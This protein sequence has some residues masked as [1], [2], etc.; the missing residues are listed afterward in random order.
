MYLELTKKRII[1]YVKRT[2]M[3]KSSIFS[4]Q[5][6]LQ[7]TLLNVTIQCS[8]SGEM[9]P[10]L[11][12]LKNGIN[13]SISMYI[14]INKGAVDFHLHLLLGQKQPT[15]LMG[16][17]LAMPIVLVFFVIS[18]QGLFLWWVLWFHTKC[19]HTKVFGLGHCVYK[20][21]LLLNF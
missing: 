8:S 15:T 9:Q 16:L 4:K 21:E 5:H 6:L 7:F 10:P 3:P 11:I 20:C 19:I 12:Y 13:Q 1:L 14:R 18:A 17:Q 2:Q